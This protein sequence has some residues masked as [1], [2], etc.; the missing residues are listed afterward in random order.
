VIK[1]L[2]TPD[3]CTCLEVL[4]S[5]SL[6]SWNNDVSAWRPLWLYNV[7]FYAFTTL[8]DLLESQWATILQISISVFNETNVSML[9]AIRYHG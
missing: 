1:R 4:E 8:E 5:L 2:E 6:V 9:E 3:S 7:S